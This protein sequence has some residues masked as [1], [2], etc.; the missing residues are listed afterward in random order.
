M[1]DEAQTIRS[2][3]WREVFP[4]THLFRAFRIAVHPSKLLLAL[5]ALLL[6]YLGGRVL[7]GLWPERYLVHSSDPIYYESLTP[8]DALSIEPNKP[9]G[10]F[11]T[12]FRLEVRQV[13]PIIFSAIGLNWYEAFNGTWNFVA[14]GPSWLFK[15][16]PL[17]AVL[18]VTWFLIIWS[19]FGGAISRI[20]AVHVAR[21]E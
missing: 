2:I 3:N 8:A 20:A 21:D 17:F 16:H 4:F 11:I 7:D 14:R 18:F 6:I 9:L 5:A 13:K 19:V 12:F 1:A 15:N 10:I